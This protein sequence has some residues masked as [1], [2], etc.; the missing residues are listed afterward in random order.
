MT[1]AAV[2]ADDRT[3]PPAEEPRALRLVET[4]QPG[5]E[6]PGEHIVLGYN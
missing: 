6:E 4:P 5:G 1:A 2:P 3:P